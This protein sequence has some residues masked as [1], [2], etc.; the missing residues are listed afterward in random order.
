MHKLQSYEVF[1]PKCK[2]YKGFPSSPAFP[3]GQMQE[4]EATRSMQVDPLAQEAVKQSSMFLLQS[5]PL[6]PFTQTQA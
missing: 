4:N 2:S 1:F 5:S 3:S 6:Q